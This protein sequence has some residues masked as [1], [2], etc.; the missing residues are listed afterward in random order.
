MRNRGV[1]GL[2]LEAAAECFCFFFIEVFDYGLVIHF[3][4][5]LYFIAQSAVAPQARLI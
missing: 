2:G 3:C 5:R 4:R 1:N